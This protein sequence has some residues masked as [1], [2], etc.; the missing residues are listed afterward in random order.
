M[1]IY[2]PT[3]SRPNSQRAY[4]QLEAAGLKPIL[5]VHEDQRNLYAVHKRR[6]IYSPPACGI[7]AA[8][9]FILQHAGNAKHA[10][11]DDDTTLAL[12]E[13]DPITGKCAI[14][15]DPQPADLRRQIE[16]ADELLETFA[17]GGVHTRHFVN[18]AKKPFTVNRGYPR[19]IMFYNPKLLMTRPSFEGNT[20]EDV[21]FFISCLRQGLDYFIMTSCCMIEKPSAELKTHFTQEGKNKDMLQM[22][23]DMDLHEFVRPTADG[24]ITL[25]YSRILKQAKKGL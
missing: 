11:F 10:T 9:Q 14:V 17:H 3:R 15:N 5:V 19:Q 24:R 4:D 18:Y 8:R 7:A 21:R 23:E 25:S 22:V 2:I 12:V 13:E 6:T 20:A 16:H 1:K